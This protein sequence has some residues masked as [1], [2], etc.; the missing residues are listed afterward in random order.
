MI[1][2]RM[3]RHLKS[4][5][6]SSTLAFALLAGSSIGYCAA[7]VADEP[8]PPPSAPGNDGGKHHHNP[9]YAA[10]KK[11]ADDQKLAQGDA[12]HDFMRNCMKS[13]S[14]TAPAAT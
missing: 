7:A 1:L 11:Q 9:A 4:I 8:P 12:R 10:C 14:T 13:A 2:P 5:A 3:I 6:P